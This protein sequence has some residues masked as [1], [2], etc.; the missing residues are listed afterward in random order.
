M[1]DPLT[2][3]GI[4]LTAGST[5]VNTIANN[6]VNAA[7]NDALQAER[8]RQQG[9]DKEASGINT[10]SQDRYQD[11]QGKQDQAGTDLGKY[12]TSQDVTEPTAEAA[13]PTSASN[14][15]VQ[16]EAKQRGKAQ[17][18]T[19][20][21]GNALG[22]LRAFGDVLGD[23]S[24]GQARDAG[25]LGQIN[26][27][28]QGS[29]NVLP[30]ELDQAS[31]AGDGLKLFGDVLGGVGGITTKAGIVGKQTMPTSLGQVIGYSPG[32]STFPSAPNASLGNSL[33]RL[34]GG[35]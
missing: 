5:A 25:Y 32:A 17:D 34:F 12:F 29:S 3:A 15:V 1:C 19:D 28:K 35:V 22:Q 23:T 27:F 11:F 21:T 31:H 14:I 13:L 2:I 16:E 4:A 20:K 7:R 30:Y 10:Q 26:G 6:K 33:S 9:L 8:I 18:F 24:R